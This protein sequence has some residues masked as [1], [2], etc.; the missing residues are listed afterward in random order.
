M[1]TLASWSRNARQ[2]RLP[3][4]RME[5]TLMMIK[6]GSISS[7]R[8]N[9]ALPLVTTSTAYPFFRN[10]GTK[11]GPSARLPSIQSI[12]TKEPQY[13]LNKV[14]KMG[15]FQR[16]KPAKNTPAFLFLRSYEH[17]R[18]EHLLV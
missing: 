12:L 4:V 13:H 2:V 9:A 7:R 1:G 8:A 11:D 14:G 10:A 17:Y 15:C 18:D 5:A 16:A 6:S 3:V